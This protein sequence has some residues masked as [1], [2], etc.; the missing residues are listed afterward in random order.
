MNKRNQTF[1]FEKDEKKAVEM[2]FTLISICLLTSQAPKTL[3]VKA[4][5][6]HYNLGEIR[7]VWWTKQDKLTSKCLLHSYT[8]LPRVH[9]V[10]LVLQINYTDMPRSYID[11]LRVH[12]CNNNSSSDKWINLWRY[13]C[14]NKIQ[15]NKSIT[16][17]NKIKKIE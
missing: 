14:L 17:F 12:S 9:Y 11:L 3:E 4:A 5:C 13:T 6:K 1:F 16:K 15:F 10:T 2:S 7:R 8:D